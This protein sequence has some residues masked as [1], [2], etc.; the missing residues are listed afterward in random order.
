MKQNG[1][2]TV[3]VIWGVLLMLAF[4]VLPAGADEGKTKD[5]VK[6]AAQGG[7]FEVEAGN[8]AVSKATNPEVKKFGNLMVTDHGKANQELTAIAQAKGMDVPKETS[9]EHKA[10]LEKLGKASGKEFDRDYVGIMV[11]DHEKDVASFRQAS[12]KVADPELKAWIDQTLP[13][14]EKHLELAQQ[15]HKT[16]Q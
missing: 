15:L 5:F 14:L 16:K 8:L 13:V 7:M 4:L 10:Q 3:A 12:G 1:Q 6:E 11:K 2:K 9:K